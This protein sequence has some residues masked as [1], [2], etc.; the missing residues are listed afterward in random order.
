[1]KF[2]SYILSKRECY[3]IKVYKLHEGSTGYLCNYIV[4][5]STDTSYPGPGHNFPKGFDD[6]SNP[7]KVLLSLMKNLYNQGYAMVLDK[8]YT[9]PYIFSALYHT[10]F[11]DL[12]EN[13][14]STKR[15]LV[16]ETP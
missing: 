2:R 12:E 5:T 13:E 8:L 10:V 15:F 1:M 16:V 14:R 4:Y 6:C 11:L 9:S 3:G 7:S